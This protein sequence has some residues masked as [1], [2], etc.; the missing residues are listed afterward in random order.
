MKS[1]P[2]RIFE[3]RVSAVNR[4][5]SP[6]QGIPSGDLPQVSPSQSSVQAFPVWV[7]VLDDRLDHAWR[8]GGKASVTVYTGGGVNYGLNVLATILTRLGSLLD[9]FF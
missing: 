1:Y 9:F 4:G 8:A 6:G 3:F 5:V 7:E 2:G